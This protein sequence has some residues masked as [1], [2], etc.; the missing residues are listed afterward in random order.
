MLR[1]KIERDPR[2]PKHLRVVRGE[3][4]R[5]IPLETVQALSPSQRTGRTNLAPQHTTFFG[6]EDELT[7]IAR[8]F[9]RD[10][11]RHADLGI[12][13]GNFIV[14]ET[15]SVVMVKPG[16]L[17]QA[18]AP[19][20]FDSEG[21]LIDEATK[22]LLRRHLGEFAGWVLKIARRPHEFVLQACEMDIQS[23]MSGR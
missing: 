21:S 1:K 18:F 9:L 23:A 10:K 16:V 3:G 11:Y 20:K 22:E 4:Y 12:T 15:G 7:Q 2:Q 5:L 17:V 14:A 13:G 6:R 19:M 8:S